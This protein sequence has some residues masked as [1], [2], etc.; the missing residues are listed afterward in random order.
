[1]SIRLDDFFLILTSRPCIWRRAGVFT[2]T[3]GVGLA[4]A[5]TP[6]EKVVCTQAPS[7]TWMTQAQAMKA[8]GAADYVLVR[9]KVSKGNC[10]EF[11]A[12]D[13]QGALIEAY[14][15]PV[16]GEDVRVTRIPAPQRLVAPATAR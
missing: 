6:A 12:V 1:M 2:L 14:R 15:H 16:T 4:Q 7:S 13:R 3:L 8:F 9:F 10:H 11:Y 5:S